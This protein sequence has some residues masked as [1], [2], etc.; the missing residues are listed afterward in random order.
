MKSSLEVVWENLSKFQ[1]TFIRIM[2]EQVSEYKFSQYYGI[3][4]IIFF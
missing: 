2:M 3:R 1:I 4:F